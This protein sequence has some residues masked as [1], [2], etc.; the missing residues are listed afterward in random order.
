MILLHRLSK[1][2]LNAVDSGNHGRKSCDVMKCLVSLFVCEQLEL[3]SCVVNR[4]RHTHTHARTRV[5]RWQSSDP[6]CPGQKE[7]S[8]IDFII[9]IET[10]REKLEQLM[11][12]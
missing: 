7:N 6:L 12:E 2:T 9:E 1:S 5:C 3:F 10:E 11:D 8:L 4:N